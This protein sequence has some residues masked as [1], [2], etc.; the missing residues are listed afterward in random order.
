MKNSITLTKEQ[1]IAII[2]WYETVG[3][4]NWGVWGN[5]P[6]LPVGASYLSYDTVACQINLDQKIEIDGD[7]YNCITTG[8][9]SVG[10][11]LDKNISF[12]ALKEW[13]VDGYLAAKKANENQ[14]NISVVEKYDAL[15]NELKD[16]YKS[17]PF[18][19]FS[20]NKRKSI[21]NLKLREYG[22]SGVSQLDSALI[23][24]GRRAECDTRKW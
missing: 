6:S 18:N 8:R 13:A 12:E 10:K 23:S 2:N 17:M 22:I 19:E 7:K 11:K 16:L 5:Y 3:Q 15:T 24:V 9:F 1:G 20:N 21:I 14:Q 4:S